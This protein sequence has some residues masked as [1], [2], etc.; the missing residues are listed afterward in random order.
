MG[1]N[2]KDILRAAGGFLV[3]LSILSG[4]MILNGLHYGGVL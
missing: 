4:I 2:A 1:Y 3:L